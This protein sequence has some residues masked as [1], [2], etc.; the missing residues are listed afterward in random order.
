MKPPLKCDSRRPLKLIVRCTVIHMSSNILL[1]EDNPLVREAT[2][3]VLERGSMKVTAVCCI[4]DAKEALS[5]YA[6]A[7][8]VSDVRMPNGTGVDLHEWVAEHHPSLL[9]KFF[10]YS[11]GM[12]EELESYIIESGCP[13]FRKPID[14]NALVEAIHAVRPPPSSKSIA[15]DGASTRGLQRDRSI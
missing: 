5:Q 4:E 15:A 2:K 14:G 6:F 11:G 1:V 9:S 3:R 10:F 13:V 7:A 8:I 12:S